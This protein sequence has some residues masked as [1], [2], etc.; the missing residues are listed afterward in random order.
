MRIRLLATLLF[1]VMIAARAEAQFNVPDPAPGENFHVELGL[2]FWT[3]TPGI[4]I[5]TGGLASAGIPG[6]DFVRE[7]G[8]KRDGVAAAAQH[9][10]HE[11]LG[12]DVTDTERRCDRQR[13]ERMSAV[14][15]TEHQMI[16]QARPRCLAH[17]AQVDAVLVRKALLACYGEHGGCAR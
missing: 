9:E 11:D 6:V 3:P 16:A 1:T 15:V 4:E 10:R 7:R 12:F 13:R 14:D 17:Q 2:M 8:R 5:Q